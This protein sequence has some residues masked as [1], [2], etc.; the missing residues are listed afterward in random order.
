M[1]G[2][3]ATELTRPAI[4]EAIRKRRSY[5][6]T[7]EPI[8]VEFRVNGHLMGSEI[9]SLDGPVVEGAAEGTAPNTRPCFGP[10]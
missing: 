7:G 6:T 1:T 5:A 3:Y 8:Q 9:D 2:A 4:F 10:L